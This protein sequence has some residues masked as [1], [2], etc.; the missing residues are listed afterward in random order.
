ML[1]SASSYTC[2]SRCLPCYTLTLRLC[3]AAICAYR[4]EKERACPRPPRVVG[5][6][7]AGLLPSHS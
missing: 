3:T 4:V 5:R 2:L 1:L 6:R 7:P